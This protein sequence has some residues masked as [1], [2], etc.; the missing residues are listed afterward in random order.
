[1][2]TEVQDE[3]EPFECIASARVPDG[4]ELQLIRHGDDFTIAMGANDLMSTRVS[5]S[6]AALATMTA[7][8]LGPRRAAEWLI[9]GYGMG[10]TL[11]AALET[12][13]SDACV[14][15]AELVPEILEWA[16]GPMRA[17]TGD[18]LDDA[19][20]HL[21]GQ[22]VATLIGAAAGA[23]DAILLDVDNGPE[24]LS[25][26]ANDYLYSSAGL[27]AAWHALTADGILAIWS[28]FPDPRFFGRLQASGFDV[29]EVSVMDGPRTNGDTHI[30][31]FAGKR[32]EAR[33]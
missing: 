26:R 20:V 3:I 4:V 9:G 22:D 11:R 25:C 10:F 27:A 24:G 21:I 23:Y 19:R 12:L 6:E 5:G 32:A 1:V 2:G 8:R 28:A 33:P 13:G 14:T 16:R 29:D 31:W 30:L 7:A 18:C 15:V 17:L